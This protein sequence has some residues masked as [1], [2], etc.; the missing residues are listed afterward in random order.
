MLRRRSWLVA[1]LSLLCAAAIV[2]CGS[3]SSSSSS[4]SSTST[5]S[6]ASSAGQGAVAS[7]ASQVPAAIKS[8]GTLIVAADASYAPNEFI[9]PD[10]HTVVGMDADLANALATVMGLKANV[11]NATFDTIIPGIKSSKYDMG[12]SSFTDTLAR[13]KIVDFVDYFVAGTS[14]FT[15]ASGGTDVSGLADLCGKTVAVESGHHRGDRRQGAE[16]EVQGGRQAGGQ[17][18]RVPDPDRGEPRAIQ[19]PRAALDGR[20]AGGRVSGQAVKRPVQDHR[21]DVRH[22]ALRAGGAEGLGSWPRRCWPR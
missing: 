13:Q 21:V 19:R 2:G 11:V 1:P 16:R 4:S 7:V 3:S 5:A 17:R 10:G 6:S 14:F 18:A 15:K 9:G 22:G 20:L 8:K 12:A